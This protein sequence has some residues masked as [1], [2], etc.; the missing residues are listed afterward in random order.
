MGGALRLDFSNIDYGQWPLIEKV[1][2]DDSYRA[3][4][5]EYVSQVINDAF[6]TNTMQAT[7]DKYAAL[8]QPYAEAEIEGYTFINNPGEFTQAI[9]ELKIHAASRAAAVESYLNGQ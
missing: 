8:V 9:A 7:Y 5:N 3:I 6:E 1:Y 2:A 4:Y